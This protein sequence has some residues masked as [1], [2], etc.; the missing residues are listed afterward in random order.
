MKINK[1]GINYKL[2]VNA[3]KSFFIGIKNSTV[4]YSDTGVIY[5]LCSIK[6]LKGHRINQQ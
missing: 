3:C 5:F 2:Q 1:H 4:N 6:K